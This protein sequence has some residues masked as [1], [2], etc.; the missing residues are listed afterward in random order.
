MQSKETH[1]SK[2]VQ[3]QV[4]YVAIDPNAFLNNQNQNND[5]INLSEL[6]RVIWAGKLTIIFVTLVFAVASVVYAINQPNIYRAS[7]LLAPASQEGGAGGLAA[8]AGQF[9]GLASMAGTNIGG[10]KADKT[11]LALEVLKSRAFI[12]NF[13]TKHEILV[14]LMAANNWNIE[15]NELILDDELY[16]MVSQEW[17]RDVKA[18]KSPKP[19]GWESYEEFSKIFNVSKDKETGM[20]T[21][22]IEHYS[23]NRAVEW[24]ELIVADINSTIREKDKREAQSSIDFLTNKLE[25]T[26]LAD[27]KSVFYQLIEEQTKTMMLTEVSVEYVLKTIDPANAPDKKAKPKRALIVVLSTMIGMIFSMLIVLIWYFKNKQ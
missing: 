13:I 16:D 8:L 7:V 10:G 27:M 17:V 18:P 5:E 25:Q 6:W 11:G 26:R 2:H 23:P 24:L 9:G 22:S 4:Q 15:T 14:P 12:E 19:S 3:P 21:L 20:I 1:E